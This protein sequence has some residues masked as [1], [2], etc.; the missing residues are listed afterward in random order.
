MKCFRH[1]PKHVAISNF[2][3]LRLERVTKY[4]LQFFIDLLISNF[5]ISCV[6]PYKKHKLSFGVFQKRLAT[7]L[8]ANQFLFIFNIKRN[9]IHILSN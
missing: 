4:V 1:N 2:K 3:F 7:T 9:T 6:T 5:W 8:R